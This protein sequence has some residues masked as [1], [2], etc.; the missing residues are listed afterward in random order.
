MIPYLPQPV[1]SVGPFTIHAFGV[2]AAL[3][4]GVGYW[5]VLRRARRYGID[6]TR[7]GSVFVAILMTALA[8]GFA[9]GGRRSM[10]GS[11]FAAG[12]GAVLLGYA[13]WARSWN[14]LDLF[15]G[16]V[17]LMNVL[18]RIGC[19]LA[20]DHVGRPTTSWVGVRFPDGPR[21][22]LGLLYALAAVPVSIAI[23]W[24]SRTNPPPGLLFG[25]MVALL[26]I[27][28]LVVLRLGS[29]ISLA[30]EI[31]A[32]VMFVAGCELVVVRWP[33]VR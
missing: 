25:A 30:D 13:W 18:V 27:T 3:A 5:I 26:A 8:A 19:F 7:A 23:E 29:T 22:D 21:F 32:G 6:G 31:F 28:R 16:A 33:C 24:V 17:P 9:I 1:W 10:A 14:I 11:G 20:H 12:G 2:A 15:G 4:L